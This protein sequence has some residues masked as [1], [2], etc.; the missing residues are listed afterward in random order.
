MR[1]ALFQTGDN[2]KNYDNV[3]PSAT[4]LIDYLKSHKRFFGKQKS[5]GEK[6]KVN[7]RSSC[8]KMNNLNTKRCLPV[9]VHD[10]VFICCCYYSP[11][12]NL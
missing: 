10:C 8:L 7:A 1:L 5:K 2:A 11:L 6:V 4:L 12:T 9:T 3:D